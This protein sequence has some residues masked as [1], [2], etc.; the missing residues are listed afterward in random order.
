[1]ESEIDNLKL[2]TELPDITV[3]DHLMSSIILRKQDR[4]VVLFFLMILTLFFLLFHNGGNSQNFSDTIVRNYEFYIDP[5]T[6][7]KAEIQT[8]PGIGKKLAQ[9]IV[10][11]RDSDVN[12]FD[13]IEDMRNVNLIGKNKITIINS[14]IKINRETELESMLLTE[15]D[16][17]SHD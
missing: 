1:M 3:E 5:N 4:V 8:L 2:E 16:Y 15:P 13:K 7:T 12:R 17:S 14:F 10:T 9:N 11:Y 6:A